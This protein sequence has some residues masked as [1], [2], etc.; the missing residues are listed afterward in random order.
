MSPDPDK[1]FFHVCANTG[2]NPDRAAI[3]LV[4]CEK[5]KGLVVVD[6]EDRPIGMVDRQTLLESLGISGVAVKKISDNPRNQEIA[7]GT[8]EKD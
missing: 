2:A 5:R 1:D 4:L 3:A 7:V 8:D 6:N